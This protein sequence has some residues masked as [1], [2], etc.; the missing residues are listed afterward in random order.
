MAGCIPRH[1]AD[2]RSQPVDPDIV[3]LDL[4]RR[5]YPISIVNIVQF[6]HSTAYDFYILY[7]LIV[8]YLY[9]LIK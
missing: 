8:T 3:R 4:I 1:Y 6:I 9:Y 5:P 2:S 7:L